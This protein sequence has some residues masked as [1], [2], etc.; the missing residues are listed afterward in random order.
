[1]KRNLSYMSRFVQRDRLVVYTEEQ[2]M[3]MNTYIKPG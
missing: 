1:M 3:G 2:H